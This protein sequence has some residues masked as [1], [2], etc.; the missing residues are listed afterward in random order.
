MTLHFDCFCGICGDMTL[1]ALI[2]LGVDPKKL[3][4]ELDKLNLDGWKLN[5]CAADSHGITGTKV[6]V[7]VDSIAEHEDDHHNDHN[8]DDHH[9]DHHHHHHNTWC[10]IRT[11]I[12]SSGITDNAKRIALGIFTLIANAESEVH[13]V[14]A[15]DIAFHE[16]GA[17]DSIIDIVG[18]A[19]CIDM[20]K[21]DKITSSELELGGGTVKCAHG[22]LPVPAP[23]TL[24]LVQGLPAKTGGFDK[25][26]TTPT[27]AAI[28][29]FC[30]DEFMPK[31]IFKEI[32]SG[33]GI[34]QRK[35]ERPNVLRVSMREEVISGKEVMSGKN[36]QNNFIEEDLI[37]IETNIDDMTAEA[38]AFLM[39][40]L[41]AEGALDVTFT[42]LIM[43][44]SRPATMVSVLSTQEKLSKLRCTLFK[45]S[46]TIGFR[47]ANVH[48]VSLKRDFSEVTG[49]FGSA[50]IKTATFSTEDGGGNTITKSKIEY[51]DR[52]RIAA[53]K[54][55]TLDEAQRIISE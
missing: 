43:K 53:E 12:E 52:A 18:S 38:L 17:V 40:K 32:K 16:V 31:T 45:Y 35:M 49:S 46:T 11:M 25:E 47:E 54:N 14:A 5:V 1:G 37:S 15:E 34:G 6:T 26:M 42:P 2:D 27:G 21:P 22:I 39:E 4:A 20:L 51:E 36:V 23:A 50:K 48:R 30:V 13:G 19:I 55:I 29:H 44:K 9:H 28:V 24:K 7:L 3:C 41:F 33:F 8:H 10:E